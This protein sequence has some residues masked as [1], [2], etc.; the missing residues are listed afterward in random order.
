VNDLEGH[1]RSSELP[2][3][4]GPY[5]DFLLVVCSNNDSIVYLSRDTTTFTG[6]CLPACDLEKSFIFEKSWNYK[7]HAF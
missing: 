3:F 2:L 6:S 1:W 4:D 7:T 5:Y